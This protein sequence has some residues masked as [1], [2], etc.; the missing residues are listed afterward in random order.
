VASDLLGGIGLERRR[1]RICHASVDR[2][3]LTSSSRLHSQISAHKARVATLEVELT[4]S[5][6]P[7][8][9]SGSSSNEHARRCRTLQG[10]V[11]DALKSNNQAFIDLAKSTL[12]TFHEGAQAQLAAR[13][14]AV[15]QLVQ[16]IRESLSKW[17][18]QAR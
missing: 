7:C 6:H 1:R 16:P 4:N 10:A 12:E 8:K 14:V 9:T 2:R 18:N 15:D 17:T 3:S 11:R 5:G 13:Q